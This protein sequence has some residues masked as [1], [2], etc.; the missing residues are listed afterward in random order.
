[1]LDDEGLS[2]CELAER[3]NLKHGMIGRQL[4]I[5]D[6][7][8]ASAIELILKLRYERQ[9]KQLTFR[10]LE[11][12]SKPPQANHIKLIKQLVNLR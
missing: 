3:E 4:K 8:S 12:I 1:M 5:L 9:T 2:I 6:R 7:L 11:E 10:K